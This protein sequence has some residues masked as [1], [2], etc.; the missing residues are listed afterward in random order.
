[1]S[2]FDDDRI[3]NYLGEKRRRQYTDDVDQINA[4]LSSAVSQIVLGCVV[5]AVVVAFIYFG[6]FAG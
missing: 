4:F 5:L 2:N 6:F 1:M 3:Y